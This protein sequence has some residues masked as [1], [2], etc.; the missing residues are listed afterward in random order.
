MR[1]NQWGQTC[2]PGRLSFVLA[3]AFVFVLQGPVCDAQEASYGLESETK[4]PKKA[5]PYA[6]E[7]FEGLEKRTRFG[8][9][10]SDDGRECYYAVALNDNGLFR[11]EIRVTRQN[12]DSSWT[13]PKPVL[14]NEK[15]Y[16]YV[17]PHFSPDGQRLYFIYTKPADAS[18]APKRQMFDIW[19]VE[20]SEKGWSSPVNVP[21]PISTNDANEYFVSLTTD[22]KM[23]FGSN[24]D[25]RNNFDLYSAQLGQDGQYEE[26]TRLRGNVNTSKYE[27][28]VFVAPDESYVIFSSSGR[29]DGRGQ[30]D[31]YVSFKGSDGNWSAGIN[32]GDNVNS[33]QQE[34]A[35]S[36]S[37]D[38]KVLF[39]SRGG[40][41]HW[42]STSVIDDLRR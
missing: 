32:L 24:R 20:R 33:K 38:Q 40:V 36:I 22:K 8:L 29:E 12:S 35:P 27:A 7:F 1:A 41:I 4:L 30:G 37:R 34:F 16:K 2:A 25:D 3:A 26:P 14:P 5:K 28:D 39:F 31:L 15:K 6:P 18:K 17:D 9:A 21:S 23:F 42:V 11:E 10:I 13:E 19:Y